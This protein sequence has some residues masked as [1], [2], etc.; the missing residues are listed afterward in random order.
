MLQLQSECESQSAKLKETQA[1]IAQLAEGAASDKLQSSDQVHQIRR[2]S[3]RNQKMK[4]RLE[5]QAKQHAEKKANAEAALEATRQQWSV[6]DHERS[7]EARQL[8]VRPP[9]QQSPPAARVAPAARIA[10]VARVTLVARVTPC[11]CVAVAARA[12]AHLDT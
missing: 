9:P 12:Y 7:Q 4:E 11:A 1:M 10:P 8:E 6:V 2:D 5:R 3:E